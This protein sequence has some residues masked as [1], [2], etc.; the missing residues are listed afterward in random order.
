[1]TNR[2]CVLNWTKLRLDLGSYVSSFAKMMTYEGQASFPSD[3]ENTIWKVNEK[4]KD[5]SYTK[6][7]F[8]EFQIV[9]LKA[10]EALILHKN[11]LMATYLQLLSF[12]HN[13]IF[14]S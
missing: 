14:F 11:V 8:L 12:D 13:C 9:Y 4:S 5:N 6:F 10:M 1:M 7:S 2:N 3:L